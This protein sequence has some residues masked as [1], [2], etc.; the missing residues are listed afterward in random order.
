MKDAL[1]T[2][3]ED[4]VNERL[5]QAEAV[6]DEVGDRLLEKALRAVRKDAMML[7]DS[8][9]PGHPI[10]E[11]DSTVVDTFIAIMVD[12]R[13]ST[14]HL[15][16]AISARDASA[17]QLKRVYFETTALLPTLAAVVYFHKGSITEYLGDGVL[18]LFPYTKDDPTVVYPPYWAASDC[19]AA[20]DSVINP[21]LK[22]R[23][24]LP[25][26]KIGVGLSMSK[27]L[28]NL[29]GTQG[30]YQAKVFGECVYRASKLSKL[31]NK[32]CIDEALKLIW[33]SGK[34]GKVQFQKQPFGGGFEGFVISKS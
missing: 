18:G 6:W 20:V 24:G 10:V 7:S 23:Y 21:A 14:K 30:Y 9:I 17:S 16:Q 15:M 1:R 8:Q 4:L 11:H 27:A 31:E 25:P 3:L 29:V 5:D 22:S 19:L 13:D 34:D 32:I 12:M 33:P 28:V 26:L 2:S